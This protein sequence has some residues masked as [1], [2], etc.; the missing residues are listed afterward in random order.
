MVCGAVQRFDSLGYCGC[1]DIGYPL[2]QFFLPFCGFGVIY[3][4]IDG[5]HT[6]DNGHLLGRLPRMLENY[7]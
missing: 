3:N 6:S 1:V 2:D 5:S 7:R 4:Q